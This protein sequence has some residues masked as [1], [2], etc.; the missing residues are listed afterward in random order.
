MSSILWPLL[1]GI[2]MGGLAVWLT[3]WVV[4]SLN[5]GNPSARPSERWSVES[6]TAR[7]ERE[8]RESTPTKHSASLSRCG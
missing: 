7:I 4:P 8:R 3:V 1:A 6:I 5:P 2:C